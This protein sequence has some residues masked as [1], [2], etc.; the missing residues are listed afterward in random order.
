MKPLFACVLTAALLVA[1]SAA[2]AV[3]LKVLS[4][5]GPR[6]AVR[7]LCAQFERASGDKID[8]RF[9]VNVEVKSKIEAGESFDVVIGNPPIIDALIKDRL[10]VGPRFDIG[11]AGLGVAVKSGA[12]KPDISS[13]DAFK[14]ALLSAK[15]V[16]YPGK[17]AS[18]IYFVSLLDRLGI[19]AEMKPKLKPMAAEDTV[20]VVAR[21]EADMVVVVATRIVDVP[22]VDPVGPIPP[23]LQTHIGFAVGLSVAA[24]EPQAAKALIAFL[25][26]PG[27]A[28]TLTA[29]GV[30]PHR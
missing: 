16:A 18:G 10:V 22:G 25:S 23:V 19:A 29:K 7:E 9:G 15:A 12:P 1:A 14:Q 5:N 26:G 21:G 13:V 2:Q 4:G 3:E 27:A 24:K 20:E 30:E 11:R 28:A 6:A 8:L 17:G